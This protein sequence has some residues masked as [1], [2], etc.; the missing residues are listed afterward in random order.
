MGR[1]RVL[2]TAPT[3]EALAKMPPLQYSVNLF[4]AGGDKSLELRLFPRVSI[5]RCPKREI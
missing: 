3:T 2:K 1:G 5:V 4:G